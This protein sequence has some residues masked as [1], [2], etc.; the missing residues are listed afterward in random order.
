M[1][2]FTFRLLACIRIDSLSCKEAKNRVCLNSLSVSLSGATFYK[3]LIDLLNS[4][5]IHKVIFACAF[6]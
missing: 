4:P 1:A 3:L 5:K 2:T 6:Q